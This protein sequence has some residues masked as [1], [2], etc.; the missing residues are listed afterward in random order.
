MHICI[1]ELTSIG[2]DNGLSPG[3]RQAII[4][5]NAGILLIV[6]LGT[7]FSEIFIGIEIFP[8]K[9][10]CPKMLSAKCPPLESQRNVLNFADRIFRYFFP[11]ED[12][13]LLT[14]NIYMLNVATVVITLILITTI[15]IMHTYQS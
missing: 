3:R 5:T 9:K 8:L 12:V 15:S 13:K 7:N 1:S 4:W 10:L 11:K 6:P 14:Q 2:S